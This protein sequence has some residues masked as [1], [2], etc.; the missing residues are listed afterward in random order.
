MTALEKP[1]TGQG[2]IN[3][4]KV[5]LATGTQEGGATVTE[6]M[7]LA[8]DQKQGEREKNRAQGTSACPQQRPE[9]RENRHESFVVLICG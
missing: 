4:Q 6:G 7:A 5:T 2:F 8:G 3:R 9:S 1:S